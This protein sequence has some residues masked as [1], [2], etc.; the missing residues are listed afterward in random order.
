MSAELMAGELVA[1]AVLGIGLGALLG[2]A[3]RRHRR[4]PWWRADVR[5]D[6]HP[7]RRHG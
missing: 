1:G 4:R 3:Y 2:H 6:G 5:L 7:G